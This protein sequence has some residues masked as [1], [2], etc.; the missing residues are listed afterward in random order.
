MKKFLFVAVIAS[1]LASCSYQ[2]KEE[3]L[4][5]NYVKFSAQTEDKAEVWGVKDQSGKTIVPAEYEDINMLNPNLI[6][7]ANGSD[8]YVYKTD[9]TLLAGKGFFTT[10]MYDTYLLLSEGESSYFY[11][12]ANDRL[13]GPCKDGQDYGGFFFVDKEQPEALTLDG[14][15]IVSGQKITIVKSKGNTYFIIANGNDLTAYDTEGKE[16]FP[17]D[18][19]RYV[20]LPRAQWGCGDNIKSVSTINEIASF[21]GTAKRRK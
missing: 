2:S 10:S 15:T 16:L 3:A 13:V 9:G 1:M 19:K 20:K 5:D 4:N 11:F 7:A 17:I 18:P 14:K 21:K 8:R 6:L 12:F